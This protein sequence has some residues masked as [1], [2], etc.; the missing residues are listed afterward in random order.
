MTHNDPGWSRLPLAPK[1]VIKQQNSGPK[2]WFKVP[3]MCCDPKGMHMCK[4]LC[5]SFD[6]SKPNIS[7]VHSK[8]SA[9]WILTYGIYSFLRH[10]GP[11]G[12]ITTA[13][14]NENAN[15]SKTGSDKNIHTKIYT[16]HL[17]QNFEVFTIFHTWGYTQTPWGTP[18]R[19]GKL[20][21]LQ[22]FAHQVGSENRKFRISDFI[23][24]KIANITKK[25][26]SHEKI[27]KLLPGTYILIYV[28]WS[29]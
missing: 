27:E 4:G 1:R 18:R 2:P 22:N 10:L 13:I 21:K 14:S 17:V 16:A 9:I 24:Q 23:I 25:Y 19:C 15:L 7:P 11:S 5:N 3:K 20:W 29:Q 12:C 28:L 6:E 26:P 8:N